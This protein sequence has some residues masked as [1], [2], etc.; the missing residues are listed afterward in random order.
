MSDVQFHEYANLSVSQRASI[1]AKAVAEAK[2]Q[3]KDWM[4]LARL[5]FKASERE[6]C[7]V[8]GQYQS[9]SEAHHIYPLSLQFSDGREM[10]LHD[11]VWLCPTHHMIVHEMIMGLVHNVCPNLD[12]IPPQERDICDSFAALFIEA[13]QRA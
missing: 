13:R 12:G 10:P 5:S 6:A 4:R 9:V 11:H 1:A 2:A 8:C 3:R 7:A